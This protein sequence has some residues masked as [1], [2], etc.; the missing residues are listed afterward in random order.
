M[1]SKVG[2][3]YGMVKYGIIC[4]HETDS[5]RCYGDIFWRFK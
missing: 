3:A 4:T 5:D 1:P 2:F